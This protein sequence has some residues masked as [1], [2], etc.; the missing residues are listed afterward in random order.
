MGEEP[1]KGRTDCQLTNKIFY[2]FVGGVKKKKNIFQQGP[3]FLG[4]MLKVFFVRPTSLG[5][6]KIKEN[7]FYL[8]KN[9]G[10]ILKILFSFFV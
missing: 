9:L 10:L 6:V 5:L 7:K 4:L 3:K 2:F 1:G 8:L